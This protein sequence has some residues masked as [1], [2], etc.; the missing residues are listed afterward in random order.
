MQLHVRLNILKKNERD[1]DCFI[2]SLETL[3]EQCSDSLTTGSFGF[4]RLL[5]IIGAMVVQDAY[6][7]R[8]HT[9][10][11]WMLPA[12]KRVLCSIITA[13]LADR[14]SWWLNQCDDP[15]SLS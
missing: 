12:S 3:V 5:R 14:W 13:D 7:S 15:I 6:D 1:S 4:S 11:T 9:R 2:K 10:M 8:K